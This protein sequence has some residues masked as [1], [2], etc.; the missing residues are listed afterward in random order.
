MLFRMLYKLNKAPRTHEHRS[1]HRS[2]SELQFWFILSQ[3]LQDRCHVF[4]NNLLTLLLK[5]SK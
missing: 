1:F 5:I 3:L 4:V 2:I